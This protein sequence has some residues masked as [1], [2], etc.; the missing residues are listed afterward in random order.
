MSQLSNSQTL[1]IPDHSFTL[2]T[3]V[4]KVALKCYA[5]ETSSYRI[6]LLEYERKQ[7][8]RS[9]KDT[10]LDLHNLAQR[11]HILVENLTDLQQLVKF[12]LD[13]QKRALEE[14]CETEDRMTLELLFVKA[15]HLRRWVANYKDRT[16]IRIN[17]VSL[18]FL[19]IIQFLLKT[20][21]DV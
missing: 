1:I 10:T 11:W 3:A 20:E 7:H 14:H 19:F 8:L 5:E 4:I 21:M 13:S 17:L 18:L 15:D 6:R 16:N 9:P 2:D 12:I